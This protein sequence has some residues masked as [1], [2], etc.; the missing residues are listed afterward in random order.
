MLPFVRLAIWAIIQFALWLASLLI[1]S[2]RA[3]TNF[4]TS[5][6]SRSKVNHSSDHSDHSDYSDHNRRHHRFNPEKHH[7]KRNDGY[8]QEKNSTN[9][10]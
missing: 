7:S 8:P 9:S 10:S 2:C 1:L 3:V 4:R 6:A 5:A